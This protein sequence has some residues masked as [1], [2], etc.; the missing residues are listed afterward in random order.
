VAVDGEPVPLRLVAEAGTE[1]LDGAAVAV[2]ACDRV[3][4][5]AGT[6]TV[7]ALA[8]ARVDTLVLATED[9]LAPPADGTV[10]GRATRRG[11]GRIDLALDGDEEAV[12]V[13]GQSFDTGWTATVDG[14]PLG[15]P[16][17][18]DGQA[19]WVVPAGADR[20]VE[21]RFAPQRTYRAA[22]FLSA[23]GVAVCLVLLLGPIRRRSAS[24][25]APPR[26]RE[27]EDR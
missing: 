14:R 27:D 10:T 19:A 26:S 9:A 17:E 13:T 11:P 1:T 7:D 24:T 12:V 23:L 20:R 25:G 2:E 3:A 22:L 21:L 15:A 5:T 18:L 6:H 16:T 4:L 8:G